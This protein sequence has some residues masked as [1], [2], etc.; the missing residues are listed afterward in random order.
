[1]AR[2]FPV[3][4]SSCCIETGDGLRYSWYDLDRASAMLANL[5]AQLAPGARRAGG[6]AGRQ[7]ARG[8]VAVSGHPARRA[9]VLAAEHRL[10]ERRGRVLRRQRRARADRLRTGPRSLD[11]TD[12]AA[13]Q[14]APPAH[15]GRRSS[16]DA[17]RGGG[18]AERSF[19]D[20]RAARGRPRGD[21]LH[22]GDDRSQQGRDAL[23]RQPVVQRAHAQ[24]VL[25]L[26]RGRRA[27][28]RAADLSRPRAVR[29]DPRRALERQRR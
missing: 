17:A 2:S 3:D 23:A 22:L 6:G 27:V 11:R 24:A 1:M 25:A 9:G 29:R 4:A 28:A 18:A 13:A 20:G 19:R 14:G 10:P 7:V 5:L 12:R 26:A 16:R 8:A 21:R 15:A